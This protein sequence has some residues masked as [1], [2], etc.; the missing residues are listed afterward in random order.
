VES[1]AHVDTVSNT[2]TAEEL[3]KTSAAEVRFPKTDVRY[4]QR[5]IFRRRYKHKN[6]TVEVWHYSVQLTYQRRREEF[7]LETANK[8]AA[9]AKA[10][11]IYLYVSANGWEATIAKFKRSTREPRNEGAVETVGQFIDAIQATSSTRGRTLAEYIR[12]FRRIVAGAFGIDDPKKYDYRKGGRSRWLGRVNAVALAKITPH[13]IQTWKVAFFAKGG[14]NPTEQ[15]TAKISINSALRG[16]RSLFSAKRLKFITLPTGFV[17]PFASV[18]LEPR[19]S[20]RYRSTFDVEALVRDAFRDLMLDPQVLKALLLGAL[21]GL[22]RGE[23]DRLTWNALD[24]SKR[25]LHIGPTE[26]FHPKSEDSIATIDLDPEFAELFQAF[27]Q[28]A[29]SEEFVIESPVESRPNATYAHYRC[30]RV[31]E[32]LT[33]WLG[34]HGVSGKKP[35]HLLRKEFGSR[36]C[37]RFGIYAA[38]RALRH[39]DVA[40]TA[41]HYVDKKSTITIGLGHLLSPASPKDISKS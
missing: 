20:M 27:K 26:H 15:R 21:C 2:K 37:D 7:A 4:W 6:Q 24:F 39:S 33:R 40:I 41:A 32:R 10:R 9:G 19:Q 28:K 11:E 23:I 30:Q 8:T 29:A 12:S 35:L 34:A 25:T 16:A 3:L 14:Q 18:P 36:I 38:S 17:S 31:F 1:L 13:R 5:R 22:R